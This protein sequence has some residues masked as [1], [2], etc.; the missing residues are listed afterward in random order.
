M[1]VNHNK[2]MDVIPIL[3]LIVLNKAAEDPR[4][5]NTMFGRSAG[6]QQ[7]DRD[8]AVS[9]WYRHSGIVNMY[10]LSGILCFGKSFQVNKIVIQVHLNIKKI[11]SIFEIRTKSCEIQYL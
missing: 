4:G 8:I 7:G 11:Q 1:P 5:D 2:M 3:L 9:G 6:T 10:H